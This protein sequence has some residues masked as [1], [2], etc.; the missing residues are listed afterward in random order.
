MLGQVS[1]PVGFTG[2]VAAPTSIT[3]ASQVL[4]LKVCASMPRPD[5]LNFIEVK[6]GKSLNLIG[7][8][9]NFL[10]RTPMA[11]YIDQQLIKGT[12]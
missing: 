2:S 8:G 3:S 9:G 7:T 4:G 6:L 10:K 5:T 1:N 12:L 11:H